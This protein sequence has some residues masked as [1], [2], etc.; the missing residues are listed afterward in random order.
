MKKQILV[1]I[2]AFVVACTSPNAA[3]PS[4]SVPLLGTP[5]PILLVATSTQT[6][7]PSPVPTT[8]N[9]ARVTA[10][11]VID[12]FMLRDL[13]GFGR[14]PVA[15][16]FLAENLYTVNSATGNLSLIQKGQVT[17]TIS[18][19]GRPSA[20]AADPTQ[21]RLFVANNEDKTLSLIANDAVVRTIGIGEP[22]SA[23]AF[24]DN[25]L[26]VGLESKGA[27]LV[28]DGASLQQWTSI[29][30]PKAW[31]IT[32]LLPDPERHRLYASVYQ[33]LAVIDSLS[34][35]LE[36]IFDIKDSSYTLAVHPQGNLFYA[37]QYDSNARASFLV[38]YDIGSVKERGRV[39][40]GDDPR[41]VVLT[42]DGTRVYV[43]NTFSHTVSVIDPRNM[44]SLATI[45]VGVSPRALA[46]DESRHV[47]YVANQESNNLNAIDTEKMVVTATI[48]LAIDPT[49]VYASGSSDRAFIAVASTN[50][51]Y[52]VN[53][54]GV[55]K[56]IPVGHHPV[57][58]VRDENANRIIVANAG[59]GT[60]S[61]IEESDWSV[62]TTEPITRGLSTV[63]IDSLRSRLFAGSVVLDLQTL[64][65][66]DK[67][68]VHGAT[69]GSVIAPD[70][71][72][73]N[74]KN[75][76]IYAVAWNGTPGS[77]SRSIAYSVDG[78][79]L[80]Q[81]T[82]FG[83]NGNLSA[84]VID[85]D[86]DRVFVA[87]THPLAYTSEL[88]IFDSN[89]KRLASL[90][91]PARTRGMAYNP[92]THHL[93]LSHATEYYRGYGPTPTPA[94]DLVE[95]LD[96][97]SWG[98]VEK[99]T[100]KAPGK[101]AQVGNLIFV[102]SREDGSI[103]IVQDTDVHPPPSP[104]P[105]F[106]PSPWQTA[107]KGVAT[108]SATPTLTGSTRTT[109]QACSFQISTTLSSRIPPQTLAR[110]GCA[111]GDPATLRFVAQPFQYGMMV[112]REDEKQI[113]VLSG[114]KTS[115]NFADT[116]NTGMP[117][118]SCPNL[119][120]LLG[121][122]KP[123]RG[124]G[125]VWCESQQVRSKVGGATGGE[126]AFSGSTLRFERGFAF[127]NGEGTAISVFTDGRWE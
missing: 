39:K 31:G 12:R 57:D 82:M 48:P 13:P 8:P 51:I 118:D 80:Q 4:A 41:A 46:L 122:Q 11:T 20:I 1:L 35:R 62:R 96:A 69:V 44:T 125:K 92:S 105:T 67:L 120:V 58:I 45:P 74:P 56:E 14:S 115:L 81:R 106:T 95:I 65:P 34:W 26:Y 73:Y 63:A 72:R 110:L 25:R 52:A 88:A 107:T 78:A 97:T 18:V 17:A 98:T 10:P 117:E 112:W 29:E 38:S 28:L 127:L 16:A 23:L 6:R 54:D 3:T 5:V 40:T 55:L 113:Y 102:A 47:L 9:A 49:S 94:D 50:S 101:M 19:G 99:L 32:T 53:R 36:S 59:D 27:I 114:D 104:T 43:A 77:N 108:R 21:R 24:M 71:V 70:L 79:T 33:R 15:M 111:V 124:F 91:L 85:P 121:T 87:G 37:N 61:I 103:T 86:T 75:S 7:T 89:D 83:P 119:S 126:Y 30:V 109:P 84:L 60:L 100:I 22:V 76:R 66:V 123:I 93:F 64:T 116:W 90:P 42:R 2:L 68:M